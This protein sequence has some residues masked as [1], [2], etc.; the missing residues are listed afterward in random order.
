[1]MKK[2]FQIKSPCQ[3]LWEVMQ[4]IPD[5]KYCDVC[6]KKVWD[7]D[8][9]PEFEISRIIKTNESVCGKKSFIKPTFSSI[10][11]ALTL[12]SSITTYT[13]AQ[14]KSVIENASHNEI[15]IKG[16]LVSITKRKLISGEISLVTLEKLYIAK[17]DEGGNFILTL[18]E[19]ALTE[20]NII[21][22]DYTSLDFNN[23][24]YSDSKSSIFKNNELLGKQDFEIEEKYT[25]IGA[26]VITS[27]EP[28]DLYFLDGKK[29]GKRKF[30]KL[31][32][33]HPEYKYLAFY[34]EAIVQ[35]LT[36]RSFVDNL[37]LLYSK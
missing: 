30:E 31:R 2:N 8:Q 28:P 22:I 21:R 5:G 7:L 27:P 13:Q 34:N 1:M 16:R 37:Y 26:V 23:K 19:K 35:K 20:Y 11:L 14:N 15:I 3:Q 32:K 33:E 18:P 36:K 6:D 25:T 17:A 29:I 24:E 12:T 4:E 9:F 10:F